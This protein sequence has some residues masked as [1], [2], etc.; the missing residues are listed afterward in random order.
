M[1]CTLLDKINITDNDI[2]SNSVAVLVFLHIIF[3]LL[4]YII[5]VTVIAPKMFFLNSLICK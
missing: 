3:G 4:E 1:K 5:K 2:D